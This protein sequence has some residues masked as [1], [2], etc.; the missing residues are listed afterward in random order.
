MNWTTFYRI[1][2]FN[3][4]FCTKV[5][6]DNRKKA[7]VVAVI[8]DRITSTKVPLGFSVKSMVG[9][10]SSL[11]NASGNTNFIFEVAGF[12]G[13]LDEI[14]KISGGSKVRD[15]L[16]AIIEQGGNVTFV[17]NSSKTFASNL[18]KI[19]TALPKFVARMLY[20]YFSGDNSSVNH[21]TE[22]LFKDKTLSEFDL[23]KSDYEYKIKNLLDAAALGM[24]PGT[25]WNGLTETHGGYIVVKQDGEVVCYHLYNRDEFSSYLYE[26]TK[27]ESA[28]TNRH[29]YGKLYEENGK[30]FFKL[31]LQ[32]RFL[33]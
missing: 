29:K 15:R 21:L 11:L 27:F 7:D 5:K 26:N 3:K 32:I 4:L 13:D 18:K 2:F 23:S 28:G 14:N 1:L 12:I 25:K 22:S 19:D 9:G 31:N 10:A 33:K 8:H 16:K 6:A 24:V 30:L 20:R 17:A